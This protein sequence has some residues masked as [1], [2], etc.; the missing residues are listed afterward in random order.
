MA[1]IVRAADLDRDRSVIIPFLRENLTDDS[2]AARFDWLYLQNPN[3]PAR[4]WIAVNDGNE[5]VVGIA[6][7]FPRTMFVNG[8]SSRGYVL[9]DF[10]ISPEC[11]SLGPALALQRA[12]LKALADENAIWFDFPSDRMVAI[13]RR[14][15]I[16]TGAR[17][18]R[19]VK[20]M[21]L[22]QKVRDRVPYAGLAS[23]ISAVG[24]LAL[25]LQAWRPQ[26]TADLSVEMHEADFG[27]E[28][29]RL[30][31][32]AAELHPAYGTRSAEYLNW[33]Y[34]RNPLRKY[35][36]VACRRRGELVAYAI[37]A[38]SRNEWC[39]SDLVSAD[40]TSVAAILGHIENLGRKQGVE[41][42]TAFVLE[43]SGI[44]AQ[45]KGAGYSQRESH[46][47]VVYAANTG[48][49]EIQNGSGW[50]LMDGDRE[51]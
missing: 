44:G 38:I 3:G 7:A 31:R 9:G 18:A 32:L 19:Y 13:Y 12:C 20:L 51:S 8:A 10:C 21:R 26:P 17:M 42:V 48:S 5:S 24:N 1:I 27:E 45:V 22:D 43:Q 41:R 47:V 46:P 34:R 15:G 25:R 28:F 33:R 40:E 39:V 29:S 49:T 2:D 36:A 6:G 14:L 50:F 11:R 23:G 35:I 16:D 37:I 4:V 30:N